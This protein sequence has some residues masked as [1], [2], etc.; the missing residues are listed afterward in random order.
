ML[1]AGQ[2]AEKINRWSGVLDGLAGTKAAWK[3]VCV[4][5]NDEVPCADPIA[6]AARTRPNLCLFFTWC[7]SLQRLVNAEKKD[8]GASA[9]F[10][11][12]ANENLIALT[13]HFAKRDVNGLT[14]ETV[15]QHP[16][17]D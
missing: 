8:T 7:D 1:T 14:G 6:D 17:K 4:P 2:S 15:C 3:S 12:G 5:S 16:E 13:A 9:F 10:R 11:N